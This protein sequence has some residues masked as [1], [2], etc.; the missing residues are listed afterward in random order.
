MADTEIAQTD[1]HS[2]E[3]QVVD[4]GWRREPTDAPSARFG[5]HGESKTAMRIAGWISGL[6]LLAMIIGN[7][8]GHV[9][10]LYLIG[11]TAVLW[12]VLLRD[13][14]LSRGKWKN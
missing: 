4:T 1:D 14:V 5:W 9:E 8:K 3:V 10:D 11:V 13:L 7:H 12:F 2:H 6:A